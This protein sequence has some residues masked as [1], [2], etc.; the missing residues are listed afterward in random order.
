MEC[1][2]ENDSTIIK[3]G[4]H[5]DFTSVNENF[6][7]F[8]NLLTT[9]RPIQMIA[10]EVIRIDMAGLQ[11]L[12]SFVLACQQNKISIHCKK[13]SSTLQTAI[14]IAGMQSLLALVDKGE[15]HA[16]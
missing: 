1:L 6:S 12:L 4:S 14:E 13:F 11:L 16:N 10:D 15:K 8:K 7:I 9:Q 3:L 2:F 5:F